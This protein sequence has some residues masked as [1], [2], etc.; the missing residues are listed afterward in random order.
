MLFL[1]LVLTFLQNAGFEGAKE[2]K[3]G[4]PIVGWL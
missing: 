3:C 4:I 1:A 2:R